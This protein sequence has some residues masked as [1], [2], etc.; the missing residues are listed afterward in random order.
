MANDPFSAKSG[1]RLPPD[2]IQPFPLQFRRDDLHIMAFFGGH[3]DYEAVEAMIQNRAGGVF[4]IRA[5]LTRH[6]Q[7]QIDHINDEALLEEMQGI[8]REVCHRT[9]VLKLESL[10]DKRH[11][12]LEFT[13][14]A[15]EPIVLDMITVGR[16]DPKRGGLTDPGRHSATGSLP[17]MWRGASTLA[18]RR[19]QVTIGGVSYPVP[20]KIRV[21]CFVALEGYYTE[22]HSIGVIRAGTVASRLLK[23]PD[24][25]DV[26]AEWVFESSGRAATYRVTSRAADG[27][28]HIKKLDGSGEIVTAHA[29]DDQ[30]QVTRI[31]LPA[32]VGSTDGL[33]LNF[34]GAAGFSLFME[35]A[36][37]LV[38]GS[39]EVAEGAE[40][41]IINLRPEQPSWAVDRLVRVVCKR[42]GERM[43][44]VTSIGAA[45]RVGS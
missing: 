24:R 5:I 7:S 31:N 20:V 29:V 42:E 28:L 23:R 38:S 43:T 12:R 33:S 9:I 27:Q 25:L 11:A 35:G 40:G 34:G 8:Q 19:T 6:D 41:S 32:D 4:S 37:D 44:F 2:V 45:S 39:V 13:S 10:G 17:L 21:F 36:R 1:L 14:H 15:G 22:H 3:P 26:G 18:A 16:P 30:L